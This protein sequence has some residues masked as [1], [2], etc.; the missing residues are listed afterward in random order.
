MEVLKK[1]VESGWIISQVEM[2]QII[3]FLKFESGTVMQKEN[4]Q[5][6]RFLERMLEEF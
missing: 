1:I 2:R 5:L 6:R 3:N 4:S